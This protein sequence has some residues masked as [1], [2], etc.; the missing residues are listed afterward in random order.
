MAFAQNSRHGL[1]YVAE[2]TFGTT[3]G[4]PSM[5][6]LRHT[7]TSLT[8]SKETFVSAEIRADRQIDDMRHGTE[9]VTGDIGFELSYGAFDDWLEAA[10]MGAWNTDALVVGTTISSFSVERRWTDISQYQVLTGC[11]P[12]TLSLSIQPN[13]M[14]TGTMGIIGKGSSIS[15]TS[16]GSPSEV[17]SNAPFDGFSG[18]ITEGGSAIGTV[19]SLELN[20]TNNLD[21][22]FVVGAE[23]TPQLIYGRSNLTGTMTCYF[24]DAALLNKF[25]HETESSLSVT[26][27]DPAGNELQVDVPRLKY[28]GGDVPASDADG[29]ALLTLP[30]QGLYDATDGNFKLTRT[31]AA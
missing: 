20:L 25:I 24:E 28:T 26:L 17:A 18:A 10:L 21:P 14:V 9:T 30:F 15:G 7:S 5:L 12:N 8:L 3:P 19:S 11:V 16:L 23:T 6:A 31:A 1:A 29:A 2:G 22:S 13:A 4:T 27:T